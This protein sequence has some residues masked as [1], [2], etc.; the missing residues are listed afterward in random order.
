MGETQRK[1]KNGTPST[2]Q[3][4][5]TFIFMIYAGIGIIIKISQKK[6]LSDGLDFSIG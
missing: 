6:V 5:G 4:G 2:Y 3:N 1:Y